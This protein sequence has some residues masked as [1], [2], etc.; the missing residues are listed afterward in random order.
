MKQG[1]KDMVTDY[2]RNLKVNY[3][4][5]SFL[6]DIGCS[7]IQFKLLYFWSRHPRAKLSLYTIVRAEDSARID[8]RYAII[9][10]LEKGIL[11][12][13]HNG[14]GLTTYTLSGGKRIRQ[15]IEELA[16]FD[17]SE[18]INLRKQLKKEFVSPTN[19]GG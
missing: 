7:G 15:C 3:D 16:K 18:V 2:R 19:K 14:D 17:W 9:A 1:K 6:K 12:A 4:L 5:L 11:I 13:E 8:L 10:L